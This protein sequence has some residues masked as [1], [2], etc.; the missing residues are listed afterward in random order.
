[1]RNSTPVLTAKA[2]NSEQLLRVYQ[3]VT[4]PKSYRVPKPIRKTYNPYLFG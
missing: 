4:K 3:A 2:L 1:M